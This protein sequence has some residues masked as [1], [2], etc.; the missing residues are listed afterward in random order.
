MRLTSLAALSQRCHDGVLIADVSNT[1]F[2][3]RERT[4]PKLDEHQ[5]ISARRI[6]SDARQFKPQ[7]A[8]SPPL[9]AIKAIN[10]FAW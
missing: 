7:T 5:P 10:F 3:A 6:S 9:I 4:V 1:P 2:S 8:P